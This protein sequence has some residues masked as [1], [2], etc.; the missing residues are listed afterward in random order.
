MRRLPL[1][2]AAALA[3]PS[4]RADETGQATPSAPTVDP[5]TAL[6]AQ[7]EAHKKAKDDAAI[8]KDLD[9]IVRAH[10]AATDPKQRARVNALF[11]VVLR[12]TKNDD[13]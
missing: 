6:E 2:L 1:L 9:E 12:G 4:A 11:G 5:V 13:L 8:V 7:V 3:I 10:K